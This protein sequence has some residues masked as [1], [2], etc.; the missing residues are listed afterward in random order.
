MCLFPYRLEWSV[1]WEEVLEC[2]WPE[3]YVVGTVMC[4][5]FCLLPEQSLPVALHSA[6][7]TPASSCTLAGL[8]FCRVTG[9][10]DRVSAV[11]ELWSVSVVPRWST[12]NM[13]TDFKFTLIFVAFTCYLKTT[14]ANFRTSYLWYLHVMHLIERNYFQFHILLHYHHLFDLVLVLSADAATVS[15]HWL[16][17]PKC[18]FRTKSSDGPLQRSPVFLWCLASDVWF[19]IVTTNLQFYIP[20]FTVFQLF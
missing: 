9:E 15:T 10:R 18:L 16:S 11:F 17:A 2:Q 1:R 12:E 19:H 8:V 5:D 13:V 4:Q 20:F 6:C 14:C 7:A 3:I